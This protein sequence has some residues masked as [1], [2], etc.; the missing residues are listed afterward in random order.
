MA[1]DKADITT[2]ITSQLHAT[3][4][5]K[6][7]ELQAST[8]DLQKSMM[9][10]K[11]R[12]TAS[13]VLKQNE[14]D[15]QHPA[16]APAQNVSGPGPNNTV[17]Q[18]TEEDRVQLSADV[19][20][21]TY[22]S[23]QSDSPV[24]KGPNEMVL[25]KKIEEKPGPMKQVYEDR[26]KPSEKAEQL[27]MILSGETPAKMSLAEEAKSGMFGGYSQ[28]VKRL[29]EVDQDHPENP[30]SPTAIIESTEQER[31]EESKF[32]TAESEMGQTLD[33]LI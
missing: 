15:A 19:R 17:R 28:D 21:L 33:K 29:A 26:E 31:P 27:H 22:V 13:Q 5:A 18:S 4:G 6:A 32:G 23:R 24:N 11:S 1:W 25:E 10:P 16:T 3:G 9:D 2:D 12:A 30:T 14:V 7:N 8:D 20:D